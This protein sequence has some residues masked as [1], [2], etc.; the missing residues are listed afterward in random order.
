MH[1]LGDVRRLDKEGQRHVSKKSGCINYYKLLEK[2]ST[3]AGRVK[4]C[5]IVAR[6]KRIE[7]LHHRF[8]L[9]LIQREVMTMEVLWQKRVL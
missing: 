5:E 6:R 8:L 3:H 1:T 4:M 2:L 9:T 7:M